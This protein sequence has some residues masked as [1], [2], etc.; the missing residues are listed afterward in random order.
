MGER[1]IEARRAKGMTSEKAALE[2]NISSHQWSHLENDEVD[3]PM[4]STLMKVACV[5]GMDLNT[6][7]DG[8]RPRRVGPEPSSG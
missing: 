5:L 6:L 8:H 7:T 1:M 2:A 3:D 4:L